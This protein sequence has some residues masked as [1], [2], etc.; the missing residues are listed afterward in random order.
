LLEIDGSYGEGGG[1]VLRNSAA[2]SCVK[3]IPIKITNIR[4]NREQPGL[5]PQ[6]YVVLKSLEEIFSA[7]T[8]GVEIGSTEVTFKPGSIKPGKYKFEVGTAGSITLVFQAV[9]LACLNTDKQITVNVSGGTDVKWSPLWDYFENVFLPLIEKMGVKVYSDLILRGYHPR[10]GGEAII[11]INPT[12]KLKPLCIPEEQDFTKVNGRICI[13]NLPEDIARRIK[14]TVV[15]NLLKKDIAAS[16]DVQ[17]ST[18]LSA[19]VGVTLW[20]K[21]E[22]SVI[23]STALGEKRIPSEEVG[24]NAA[25]LLLEEIISYSTVDIFAFDQILPYLV[26][27]K[28]NGLS[29]CNVRNISPHASTNMW[30]LKNFY[31]DVTFEALQNEG[32]FQIKVK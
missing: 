32:N 18:S 26:L 25:N 14:N 10:G 28:E 12:K 1:Q 24:M 11:T 2:L 5:K 20:S 7:E 31:K 6:H 3:N 23:G 15:K 22:A 30:L 29:C 8:T 9:I 16:I 27:A 21:T 4:A 13:S 17:Q 19:G